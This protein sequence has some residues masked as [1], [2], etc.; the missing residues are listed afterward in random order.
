MMR[1]TRLVLILASCLLC[2]VFLAGGSATPA[3]ANQADNPPAQV[4]GGAAAQPNPSP[5]CCHCKSGA[6][7]SGGEKPAV[8]PKEGATEPVPDEDAAPKKTS[9]HRYFTKHT[10]VWAM[11]LCLAIILAVIALRIF[12]S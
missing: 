9:L 3:S 2:T 5:K 12:L 7:N 10:L 11:V 1:W 6:D 8:C 4:G